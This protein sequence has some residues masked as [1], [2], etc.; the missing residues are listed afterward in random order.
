MVKLIVIL[1][2]NLLATDAV[3]A[4]GGSDGKGGRL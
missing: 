4:A 2:C 3:R 1:A